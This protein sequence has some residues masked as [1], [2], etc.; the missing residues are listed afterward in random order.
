MTEEKSNR[1]SEPGHGNAVDPNLGLPNP[2]LDWPTPPKPLTLRGVAIG[3]GIAVMA[4]VLGLFSVYMRRTQL[5]KTTAYWGPKAIE[6]FQ[7]GRKVE[8]AKLRSPA[9]AAPQTDAT[10]ELTDLPGLSH[11]RHAFLEERH[12]VWEKSND[13]SALVQPASATASQEGG[14]YFLRFQNPAGGAPTELVYDP[15]SG[16][17][18]P[19]GNTPEVH[20][21]DRANKGVSHYINTLYRDLSKKIGAGPLRRGS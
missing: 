18:G 19:L 2:A 15:I 17:V 14:W 16:A 3:L 9:D 5:E 13:T 11:L 8:L 10:I 7:Y 20:F 21:T 6:A 4:V 12:Y 1:T